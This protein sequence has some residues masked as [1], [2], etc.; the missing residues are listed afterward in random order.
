MFQDN[1]TKLQDLIARL[2][3]K[4]QIIFVFPDQQLSRQKE[5]NQPIYILDQKE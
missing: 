3:S 1:F 4:S 2:I 5:R